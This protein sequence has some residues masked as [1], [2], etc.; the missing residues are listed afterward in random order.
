[1]N[2]A[3][4]DKHGVKSGAMVEVTHA[5]RKLKVPAWVQPGQARGA[6]TLHLGYGRT[7][8]GRTGN[9]TGFDAYTLRTRAAPWGGPATIA[10]TGETYLLA[11]AQEHHDLRERDYERDLV[12][13]TTPAAFAR[14]EYGAPKGHAA[15]A[16]AA[17]HGKEGHALGQGEKPGHAEGVLVTQYTPYKYEGYAWGMVIDLSLCVGC[18]AC[19]VACQAE[20]NIPIVGKEQVHR[21]RELHWIRIDR[22]FAGEKSN[23][24]IFFQPVL[25]MQ[26]ENAPCEVV[27]PVAA[28]SHGDEG[29]NE[30]VYNRCVGTKYCSNNC[31]Y[32]VRRFNFLLYSDWTTPSLKL[33]RNPDVTVR[34]RGVMEKCTYCVQRISQARIDAKRED[35]PIRD[36]EVLT[37]CQQAC[38]AEVITFGDINDK[39]SKVHAEKQKPHNYGLLTELNT[40]PRTTYLS[41]VSNPNPE[42]A[43]A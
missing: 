24:R 8:V 42:L 3:D 26:C 2:P 23:P 21:G 6:A 11:C 5:G 38:P 14:G 34:S 30:M 41:R 28:T 31:P 37:A 29:L 9:G 35:R 19:V 43:G 20:N 22:Y 39:S 7:R 17:E 32:K 4:A 25:C 1:L 40:S 18:N 10:K 12:R 33:Q 36:G 15:H 16:P 27:C 13:E